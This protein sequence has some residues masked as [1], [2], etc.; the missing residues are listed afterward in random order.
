MSVT[1]NVCFSVGKDARLRGDPLLSERIIP[2]PDPDDTDCD[3]G[4]ARNYK[5]IKIDPEYLY[6][7]EI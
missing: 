7:D 6:L 5:H 4:E 1:G 3:L 2:D